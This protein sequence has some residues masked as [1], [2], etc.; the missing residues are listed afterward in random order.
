VIILVGNEHGVIVTLD[1]TER[2]ME[3]L[4]VTS[5]AVTTLTP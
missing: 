5:L 4:K 1:E 2:P 3:L